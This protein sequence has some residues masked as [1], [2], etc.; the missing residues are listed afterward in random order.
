MNESWLRFFLCFFLIWMGSSYFSGIVH[1]SI[2]WQHI[3]TNTHE[4]M[5]QLNWW[6]VP[7]ENSSTN[8]LHL[9]S[10][11][12][13]SSGGIFSHLIFSCTNINGGCINYSQWNE[14]DAGCPFLAANHCS[15]NNFVQ[16]THLW[17]RNLSRYSRVT[18]WVN[19]EPLIIYNE[20]NMLN[21]QLLSKKLWTCGRI[22]HSV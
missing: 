17:M 16:L 6:M 18:F 4:Y 12:S 1:F 9:Q 14:L 22:L 3:H 10:G 13:T 8:D 2:E 5:K 11:Q 21:Q 20:T 7:S 19:F 15:I